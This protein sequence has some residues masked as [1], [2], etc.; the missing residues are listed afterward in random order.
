MIN[1]QRE[2]N[3]RSAGDALALSSSASVA[4]L[5]AAVP[6]GAWRVESSFCGN[7]SLGFTEEE[8]FEKKKKKA[9]SSSPLTDRFV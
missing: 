5:V 9:S 3:K 8:G 4:A 7:T 2:R 6:G 1:K